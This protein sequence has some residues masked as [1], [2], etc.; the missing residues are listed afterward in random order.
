MSK[1]AITYMKREIKKSYPVFIL[2]VLYSIF[3][4][5]IVFYELRDV[6]SEALVSF[7]YP[8]FFDQ[9]EGGD[10][11]IYSLSHQME[12]IHAF[13]VIVLEVLLIRQIFY[14]EN[15]AGIT[16]FLRILP[17][18]EWKKTCIKAGVGETI[19]F[20]I[21]VVFGL[22]GTIVNAI[23]NP[24]ITMANQFVPNYG[25][26]V[27][28]YAMLWQIVLLM[29]LA[30]SAIFLV[31]F[32]AQICIHN[33]MVAYAAGAG[34][35]AAPFYFV[36]LYESV[37]TGKTYEGIGNIPKSLLYHEPLNFMRST[38]YQNNYFTKEVTVYQW[39]PEQLKFL[40]LI[41][42]AAAVIIA[43]AVKMRWNIR[44]S[45]HSIVSSL[46]I[47]EFV[48]SGLF[49]CAGTGIAVATNN[50]P[51]H[52]RQRDYAGELKFWLISIFIAGVFLLAANIGVLLKIKRRKECR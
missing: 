17:V 1:P 51:M 19:I 46:V 27:N 4:F 52:I 32:A 18:K 10:L 42:L 36:T 44:Q 3:I 34:I 9:M 24:R 7:A 26:T 13:V 31:L 49:L 45:D 37:T 50:L 28:S 35:L 29:F 21:C 2:G 8:E 25:A 30:M 43:L 16:D 20:G 41:S 12:K 23:L 11:F 38:E 33:S 14:L 40:I 22:T 48:L 5:A 39:Y 47:L 6:Q 15:R